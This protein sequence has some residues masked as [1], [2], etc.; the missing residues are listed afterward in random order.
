M[1]HWFMHAPDTVAGAGELGEC[2]VECAVPGVEPAAI[3][4][5]VECLRW[6]L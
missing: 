6:W 2:V 5:L 1:H 4:G 3:E